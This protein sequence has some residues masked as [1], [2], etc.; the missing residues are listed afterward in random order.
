MQWRTS[1]SKPG[2]ALLKLIENLV[3]DAG[4]L[5]ATLRTGLTNRRLASALF[6]TP[7]LSSQVEDIDEEITKLPAAD[8]DY[9]LPRSADGAGGSAPAVASTL[10]DEAM[11]TEVSME[12]A[13][14]TAED[15]TVE[16]ELEQYVARCWRDIDTYVVFV[17]ETVDV[18]AL[19]DRIK[20][21]EVNRLRFQLQPEAVDERKF[22]LVSYDL[23][24]AGE[25]S[26][27][28]ATRLPPAR[29]RRPLEGLDE[30]RAGVVRRRR[31]WLDQPRP[32]A[33]LR[34]GPPGLET[35]IAGGGGG[36]VNDKNE[37]VPKAVRAVTCHVDEDGFLQRFDR[38]RGFS[39][40]LNE[41]LYAATAN[42]LEMPVKKRRVYAGTNRSNVFGPIACPPNTTTWSRGRRRKTCGA[43][44]ASTP[45]GSAAKAL[46]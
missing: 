24:S 44:P 39:Y 32:R 15:A 19:V 21:T 37:L 18:D 5:D 16:A 7:P 38:V 40:N 26:S 35:S 17:Q 45:A 27:H 43:P 11:P 9:L 20:D 14:A 2:A 28:P 4:D 3:F 41:M 31:G 22:V 33:A 13:R 30:G 10:A 29:R 1:L 25:S 23:K 42:P 8:D 36:F 34:R 46:R 6:Q 12:I